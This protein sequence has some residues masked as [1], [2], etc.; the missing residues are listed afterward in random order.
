MPEHLSGREGVP[1]YSRHP[2]GVEDVW[3]DWSGFTAV[4]VCPICGR[5]S[6]AGTTVQDGVRLAAKHRKHHPELSSI[7]AYPY[8]TPLVCSW[9]YT[10]WGEGRGETCDLKAIN[11]G[12]CARHSARF[13]QLQKHGTCT[14]AGC[15]GV[16]M[17]R[18]HVCHVHAKEWAAANGVKYGAL[19]V[20]GSVV[21]P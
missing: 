10:T 13:Y 7:R 11:N 12:L 20:K 9:A 1:P 17:E 16:Q 21:I 18:Q 6:L 15:F 19:G 2:E 8:I 5:N 3:V 14:Y 4:V